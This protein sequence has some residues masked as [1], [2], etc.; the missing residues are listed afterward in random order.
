[1]TNDNI[2]FYSKLHN[3][4]IDAIGI[5]PDKYEREDAFFGIISDIDNGKDEKDVFIKTFD[6][7]YDAEL[8]SEVYKLCY[9]NAKE[10]KKNNTYEYEININPAEVD[11][12]C[13]DE[14]GAAYMWLNKEED[15]GVEY[16]LCYDSGE[17]C[18][19]FYKME[20]TYNDPDYPDGYVE[21]DYDDC[22]HYEIDFNDK[23][24]KEK[25]VEAMKEV[26]EKFF[27]IKKG[28]N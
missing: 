9:C 3:E 8:D 21:T 1:M 25:L 5:E 13:H 19:A 2:E 20:K 18:S 26:M 22:E 23:N 14:W 17:C 6:L 11:K 16:N 28:E 10:T 15:A 24:W 7:V 4:L 27:D 12:N